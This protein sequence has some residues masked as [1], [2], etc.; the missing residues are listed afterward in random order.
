MPGRAMLAD[1]DDARF[2]DEVHDV[3]GTFMWLE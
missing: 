1:L 3:A 2:G